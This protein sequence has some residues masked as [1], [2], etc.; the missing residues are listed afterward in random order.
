MRTLALILF[1][2]AT[3]PYP[4]GASIFGEETV[5][6]IKLVAGQITEIERLSE[7][8]ELARDQVQLLRDLNDGIDQT[9]S[10]IQSIEEIISR[11]RGL[12]PSAVRSLSDLNDLLE[13]ANQTKRELDEL[14][15]AKIAVAD[16]A[17]TASALQSDTSYKMGQEMV[18]VGSQ[19]AVESRTASPGRA[20]QI[21]AASGS[22]QMLA[23]GVE[24]QTLAQMVQL[25]ALTLEFQKSQVQHD[26]QNEKARQAVFETALTPTR[27]GVK[28]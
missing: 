19:L 24:L 6:L 11:T 12:D 25:Q 13:R 1:A 17:I 28:R 22:A 27:N 26:L 3:S 23:Q 15:M 2:L 7:T 16:Q 5:P 4:A 21:S 14:A 20:Q 18:G 10:Q 9:V 8:L